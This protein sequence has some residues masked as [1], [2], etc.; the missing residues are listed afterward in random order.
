MLATKINLTK[1]HAH[2]QCL[3]GTGSFVRKFF[4]TKI[5][6]KIVSQH[7]NFQNYGVY[8]YLVED[9]KEDP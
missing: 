6:H 8:T 4:N 1:M 9:D 2:H 5:C 7:E 3:H